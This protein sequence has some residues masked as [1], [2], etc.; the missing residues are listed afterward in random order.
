MEGRKEL[1]LFNSLFSDI[2]SCFA[3]DWEL[4]KILTAAGASDP[5]GRAKEDEVPERQR[6]SVQKS[7]FVTSISH[8]C[9]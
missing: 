1:G 7:C 9:S 3:L 6:Q 4:L 2:M 8:M 5:Q